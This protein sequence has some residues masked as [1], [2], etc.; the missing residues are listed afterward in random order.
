MTVLFRT[1]G[2]GTVTA[3]LRNRLMRHCPASQ[4]LVITTHIATSSHSVP[5][6]VRAASLYRALCQIKRARLK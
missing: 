3:K 1:L 5:Q 2:C 4:W 6:P